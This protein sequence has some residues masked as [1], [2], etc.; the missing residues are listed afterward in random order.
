MGFPVLCFLFRLFVMILLKMCFLFTVT[1]LAVPVRS[2]TQIR[3]NM[4]RACVLY[5]DLAKS[6]VITE[7]ILGHKSE[8]PFS[9]QY[10]VYGVFH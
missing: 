8:G 7:N 10:A 4:A 3:A 5:V 2:H 6:I 9:F 1:T